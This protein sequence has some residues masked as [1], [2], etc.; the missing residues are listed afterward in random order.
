MVQFDESQIKKDE[1]VDKSKS[2]KEK[3]SC[4]L[5]NGSHDLDECKA[6]TVTVRGGAASF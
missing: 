3:E 6:Y 5:C 1:N 2:S 4:V